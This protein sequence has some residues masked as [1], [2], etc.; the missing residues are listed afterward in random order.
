M[1]WSC[2][3]SAEGRECRAQAAYHAVRG[4]AV[5]GG[6]DAVA[7]ALQSTWREWLNGEQEVGRT[8]K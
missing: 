2:E 1:T 4:Q 6:E 7:S 5:D 3:A 8:R